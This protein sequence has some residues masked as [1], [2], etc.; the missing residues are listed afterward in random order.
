MITVYEW[1]AGLALISF[2]AVGVLVGFIHGS[3]RE[4][5]KAARQARATRR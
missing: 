1:A 5:D 3:E 4:Q 2:F